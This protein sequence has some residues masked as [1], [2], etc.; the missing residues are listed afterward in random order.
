MHIETDTHKNVE[1]NIWLGIQWRIKRM[2]SKWK[3][4][5]GISLQTVL[6]E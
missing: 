5:N 4:R 1:F 3:E 6:E 2:D